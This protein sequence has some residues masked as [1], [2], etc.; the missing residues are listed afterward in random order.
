MKANKVLTS[1]FDVSQDIVGDIPLEIIQAWIGSSK[2]EQA[3]RKILE[4]FLVAGTAVSSDTAG[5][6]KLS[7]AKELIEVLGVINKPKEIVHALG[8]AI[9]GESVGVWA[10]DNTQMFYSET[11]RAD[12]IIG[13]LL[14][15]QARIAREC[16][17]K[18]GFG[19]H[20]ASFY[21]IGGGVYGPEAD[22]IEEVAEN[23][24]EGGETVISESLW[25]AVQHPDAFQVV[26]R[27]D[28]GQTLWP[29]YRVVQGPLAPELDARDVQYPAPYSDDFLS[30]LRRFYAAQDTGVLEALNTKDLQERFVVLIERERVVE[31]V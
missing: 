20:R 9:G 15:T 3:A 28:L 6:S 17:V 10:A 27:G 24:T 21:R 2:D 8:K 26:R 4:R 31:P 12:D 1:L 11:V 5:L 13:M 23:E 30:D 19:A 22:F 16:A 25:Q 18:I 14:E 7:Q 29:V